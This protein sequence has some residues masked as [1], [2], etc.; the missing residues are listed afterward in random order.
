MKFVHFLTQTRLFKPPPHYQALWSR[1][2]QDLEFWKEVV[3]AFIDDKHSMETL[4]NGY[5]ISIYQ[6]EPSHE[7]YFIAIDN[8]GQPIISPNKKIV[9]TI[10]IVRE[11]KVSI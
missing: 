11:L 4:W 9:A 6:G 3:V 7:S 10:Y 2:E 8:W 1:G 5:P